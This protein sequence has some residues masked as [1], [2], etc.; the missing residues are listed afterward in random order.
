MSEKVIKEQ[1]LAL[2]KSDRLAA[3]YILE[4]MLELSIEE[5]NAFIKHGRRTR[6]GSN[7]LELARGQMKLRDDRAY[8]LRT[9]VFNYDQGWLG[10]PT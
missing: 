2:L 3:K 4:V 9:L 6:D 8:Y 7:N 10:G 5:R 1:A